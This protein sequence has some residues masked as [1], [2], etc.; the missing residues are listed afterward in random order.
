[1]PTKEVRRIATNAL[2]GIKFNKDKFA[3][4]AIALCDLHDQLQSAHSALKTK[5]AQVEAELSH[6]RSGGRASSKTPDF[7]P[8]FADI[9]GAAA[10][11]K[12]G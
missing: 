2:D 4:D 8:G 10:G 11:R 1:M 12:M 6:L 5:T 9:F 3:R 7:P